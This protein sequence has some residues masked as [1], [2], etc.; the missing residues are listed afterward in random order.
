MFVLI[1]FSSG[2]RSNVV[3]SVLWYLGKCLNPFF[4]RASVELA[5]FTD[6]DCVVRLNPFF[7]RASVELVLST[8]VYKQLLS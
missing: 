8:D 3:P 2:R 7:V 1:P 5:E 4:V 6:Q